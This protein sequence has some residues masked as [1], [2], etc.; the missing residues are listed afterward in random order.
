M[1]KATDKKG[2]ELQPRVKTREAQVVKDPKSKDLI[3]MWELLRRKDILAQQSGHTVAMDQPGC[4]LLKENVWDHVG[5]SLHEDA[6]QECWRQVE[7]GLPA[8]HQVPATGPSTGLCPSERRAVFFE[9]AQGFKSWA[10]GAASVYRG[11][12][13]LILKEQFC[14]RD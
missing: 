12:I 3:V 11:H 5:C 13:S 4:S 1:N 14:P 2:K 10:Q 6:S 9:Y 8:T 7:S